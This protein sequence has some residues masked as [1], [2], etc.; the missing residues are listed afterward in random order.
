[1]LTNDKILNFLKDHKEEL[2]QRFSVKRIGLFGSVLRGSDNDL[3]DVDILVEL[4]HPTFDHY[5]DLKFFLEKEIGRPVDLVLSDVLKPRLKP[6]I[7]RE[8]AYA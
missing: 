2:G 5:M 7:S 3:S 1:M 4:S 6:I 8:V